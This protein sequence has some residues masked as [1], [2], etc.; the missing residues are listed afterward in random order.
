[1]PSEAATIATNIAIYLATVAVPVILFWL[2]LRL[3]RLTESLRERR[4]A[5]SPRP[6]GLPIERL[7][8]DLRRVNRELRE[9]PNGTSM[10]RRRGTQM[11]YD[12]LLGQ[13]CEALGIEHELAALPEGLDHDLERARVEVA[14]E[15]AGLVIR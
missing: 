10:V 4:A 1:M 8:A 13:A 11:A 6:Q 5:R 14:L 12:H 9:L 7:A 15:R 2:A 3:P